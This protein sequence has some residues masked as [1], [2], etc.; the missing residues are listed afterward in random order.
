MDFDSPVRIEK[1]SLHEQI[2]SQIQDM[3]IKV[4]LQLVGRIDKV[5]MAT[6]LGASR[7]PFCKTLRTLAAE[8]LIES[9][10]SRS[11]VARKLIPKDTGDM[12]ELLVYY[13][14]CIDG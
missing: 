13:F 12:L 5:S 1:Y 6:K 11:N 3:I 2:A 4:Y 7:T 10:R 9:R 14:C 8:G